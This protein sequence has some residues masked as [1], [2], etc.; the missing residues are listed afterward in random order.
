MSDFSPIYGQNP[1]GV[2]KAVQVDAS[3]NL[4]I[5]ASGSTPNVNLSQVNGAS[6]VAL[7]D[8]LTNPTTFELGANLLLWNGTNWVR[9]KSVGAGDS[10]TEGVLAAGLYGF[11]GSTMNRYLNASYN[12]DGQSGN[13]RGMVTKTEIFAF[14]GSTWDR[15]RVDTNKN[16]LIATQA[17]TTGGSTPS[18]ALSAATT[19]ATSLKASA[20]LVYGITISNTNAAARYF[21][22]YD[23]AS[24]PNVGTDTPKSTIQIPANATVA[25]VYPVGLTFTLGIAY[26]ATTGVADS[27]TGAT[28]VND[29]SMDVDYK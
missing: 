7:S 11:D 19:N 22:L 26:A 28:G 17:T 14:N 29:L 13:D 23:K 3:G 21:K 6:A 25:R 12:G 10:L 24:S 16:L 5:S 27:D 9:T 2:Q 1:S 15:L 18:H 20:G 4:I 8:A